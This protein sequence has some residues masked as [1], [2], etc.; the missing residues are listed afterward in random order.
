MRRAPWRAHWRHSSEPIEP[1]APV[2]S[3]ERAPSQPRIAFQSGSTGLRPS[4]SSIA[5]SFSSPGSER[6]SSTSCRRGTMRN[7]R[8]VRSHATTTRCSCVGVGRRHRDDQQ[9]GGGFARDLGQVLDAAQ[10]R[11]ALHLG[12][13]QRARR[14]R[15]THRVGRCRRG[16]GRAPALRRRGRRRGSGCA[17][18]P[19][20]TASMRL[21]FQARYSRRG[22]PSRPIS[23][24]G[25][26]TSTVRGTRSRRL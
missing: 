4:R 2:T 1:P 14:R 22:A 8:P 21:S 9:L 11:H 20:A 24:N 6:P 16:A 7:G 19:C 23:T 13:P 18:T 25:Y 10:H 26:S 17:P 15:G 3:T 12:A 5:T